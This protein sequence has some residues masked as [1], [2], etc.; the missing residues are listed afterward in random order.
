MSRNRDP[1]IKVKWANQ[2]IQDLNSRINAFMDDEPRPYRIV[3]NP[4]AKTIKD[5]FT[6]ELVRSIP[7]DIPCVAGDILHNLRSSLDHLLHCIMPSSVTWERFH[8][9]PV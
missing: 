7:D 5:R 9:F 3:E 8:G 2:Y 6:V 1:R 4:N